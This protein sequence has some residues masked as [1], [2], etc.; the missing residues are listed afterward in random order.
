MKKILLLGL[1]ILILAV[2]S[3]SGINY[4]I[5]GDTD[6][7]RDSV[8][9]S[10]ET[11]DSTWVTVNV[12]SVWFR[13]YFRLTEIVDSAKVTGNGN[14]RTTGYYGIRRKAIYGSRYG[15]YFVFIDWWKGS[16]KYGDIG[17]YQVWPDS[18]TAGEI[19]KIYGT[20]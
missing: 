16:K 10:I 12:D 13:I 20:Q 8:P 9:I 18:A 7:A 15:T 6:D 2:S 4:G 17:V 5:Y 3:Y 1:M 19:K 14:I 11:Y